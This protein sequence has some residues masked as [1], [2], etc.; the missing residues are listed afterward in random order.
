MDEVL[1][2]LGDEFQILRL[3]RESA[4]NHGGSAAGGAEFLDFTA[5]PV[6]ITH[7][8]A[9]DVV[10]RIIGEVAIIHARTTFTQSDGRSG[11]GRYTDIWARRN[12]E[13]RAVAAHV[14]RL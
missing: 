1:H 9:H 2:L 12:G 13:W 7:L 4:V 5:R 14:T 11:S 8:A 3:G 10:V 6:S